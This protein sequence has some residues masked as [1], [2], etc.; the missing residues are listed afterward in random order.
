MIAPNIHFEAERHIYLIDGSP[1]RSVTQVLE[2]A[3]ISDW[4]SVPAEIL[5]DSQQRGTMV[6]RACHFI[7]QRELDPQSV[8]ERITG[9]V[10]GWKA[11]RMDHELRV[12]HSE[13][14]VYRRL[15]IRGTDAVVK[16]ETDLEII[17]TLDC[18]GSI[19]KANNVIVDIKTGS[20]TDSWAPQLAAYVRGFSATAQHT[21]KRLVV[22]LFRDGGYKLH[23]FPI[24]DFARDW[25]RFRLALIEGKRQQLQVSQ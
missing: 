24:R 7:N 21:H 4:S 20:P 12:R 16:R 18:E 19:K 9:Y 2:D 23:W 11:F 13:S 25:E 1:K 6:H 5:W 17:G 15:T 14:L 22:Q 8:D 10:E 3:G